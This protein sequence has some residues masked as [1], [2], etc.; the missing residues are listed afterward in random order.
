MLTLNGQKSCPSFW[1]KGKH[2]KDYI[3]P[4]NHATQPLNLVTHQNSSHFAL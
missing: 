3:K 4:Y 1:E 2:A